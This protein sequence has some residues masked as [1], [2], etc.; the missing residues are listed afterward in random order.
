MEALFLKLFNMS[1]TAGW[2]VLAVVLLRLF[3]KKAPKWISCL[4][5]VLVGLRLV[6][7]FSFESILSLIPSAETVPQ[8]IFYAQKPTIHSGVPFVNSTVNPVISESLAPEVGTSVNPI[9]IVIFIASIAWCIGVAGMVIYALASFLRLKHKVRFSAPLRENIYI[10]DDISTPFILGVIKPKIYLPSALGEK[11]AEYVIAHEKSHLKRLD[12]LWKP[13]GFLLLTVYWF[14]PLLW[15][16]YIL[17]CR[18][19]ELACDER[20]I[21]DM[22]AEEKKAYSSALLDCSIPRRMISA[23]PLAFGE[24]GVKNRIKSILSYKKPGFWIIVVSLVACAI[25]AVCLLTDPKS[26]PAPKDVDLSDIADLNIGTDIPLIIYADDDVMYF[27]GSFGLLIFDYHSM[28]V[29]DRVSYEILPDDYGFTSTWAT[30]EGEAVY[31]ERFNE[32]P[33]LKYNVKNKK[34]LPCDGADPSQHF[35]REHLTDEQKAFLNVFY[36]NGENVVNTDRGFYYLRADDWNMKSL[37]LVFHDYETGADSA[38][39]I[40]PEL[41]EFTPKNSLVF[42]Y[43]DSVDILMP[44]LTITPENQ[45]FQF[46]WSGFSS[47]IAQGKYGF[48]DNSLILKTDDGKNTYVFD[49]CEGGYSFDAERSSEIPEYRYSGDSYETQCPVP[50]G[51]VFEGNVIYPEVEAV[52]KSPDEDE[53]PLT[54]TKSSIPKT[55]DWKTAGLESAGLVGTDFQSSTESSLGT[56][57]IL[58]YYTHSSVLKD[59][60]LALER[61]DDVL[62]YAVSEMSFPEYLYF[63]DVDGDNTDEIVFMVN[64]GGNGGAGSHITY[65]WK[66]TDEGFETLFDFDDYSTFFDTGFEFELQ[67]PFKLLVKNRHTGYSRTIDFSNRTDYI[68]AVYDE[69]GIPLDT[70]TAYHDCFYYI[71]PRDIDN[72]GVYEIECTAF[73]SLYGH[74]DGIGDSICTIKYD[75]KSREFKVVDAR[76]EIY[77]YLAEEIGA[78][79]LCTVTQNSDL[80]YSCEI[81]NSEGKVIH[82][83][84]EIP[85]EPEIGRISDYV[86]KVS[87]Q[88]GTGLS[89][90]WT[91]YFNVLT[92]E[93]S[94]IFYYVLCE[95]GDKVLTADYEDGR[96]R[97][98][99]QDIFDKD[100]FYKVCTITAPC[101]AADFVRDVQVSYYSTAVITCVNSEGEE[102]LIA[103]DIS[104]ESALPEYHPFPLTIDDDEQVYDASEFYVAVYK[105]GYSKKECAV[106]DINGNVLFEDHDLPRWTNFHMVN[107]SVL[108][109]YI[110]YGSG[111][112]TRETVYYNVYTGQVSPTYYVAYGHY[113]NNV[114]YVEYDKDI[115]S[116]SIIVRDIFDENVFYKKV[117][118]T[119]GFSAPIEAVHDVYI[120]PS[121]MATVIFVK[122]YSGTLYEIEIDMTKE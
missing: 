104:K 77:D 42:T 6:L 78:K 33:T 41:M 30:S 76:F 29:L 94:D 14:N 121:G 9:Q 31:F 114:L 108:G 45:H 57:H 56:L 64:T 7:P 58:T 17:L 34:L 73:T 83:L 24:V 27:S 109:N 82:T 28:T 112:L 16:G 63:S 55:A 115:G 8:E 69:K 2:I 48:E 20:V 50:D 100:A 25:A 39:Y 13:L 89:T 101:A 66:V 105:N 98:I 21:K 92:G 97:I 37:Q 84:D 38:F 47:Y 91:Q 119:N 107:D 46:V 88:S 4:L 90:R 22:G 111:M 12:H 118:I 60:F 72:D 61:E 85:K 122:D 32:P 36:I 52:V 40:F 26:D 75:T 5:W 44:T 15:L 87:S 102:F 18:D 62:L 116:N 99:V 96:G 67:A 53:K 93:K 54:L 117:P 71:I 51:A 113:G 80:T 49:V 65:V 68:G 35:D 3:L 23:C 86:V 43:H 70:W 74:A 19:I 11:E 110:Q 120:S 81:K 79:D 1:I 106:I 103:V 95:N 59:I 10:C